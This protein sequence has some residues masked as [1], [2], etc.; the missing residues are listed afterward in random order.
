MRDHLTDLTE[1]LTPETLCAC[2]GCGELIYG[3]DVCKECV[4]RDE[5]IRALVHAQRA[6]ALFG[7]QQRINAD[8][9]A[10]ARHERLLRRRVFIAIVLSYSVCIVLGYLWAR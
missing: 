3:A 10:A 2:L 7:Q 5:Y 8:A 1:V 4:A 6:A 9:L